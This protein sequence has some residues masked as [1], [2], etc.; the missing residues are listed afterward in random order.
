MLKS[1][2]SPDLAR[3]EAAL[4]FLLAKSP[5]VSRRVVDALAPDETGDCR[6]KCY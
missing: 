3:L 2:V 5:P 4:R 6:L 1:S